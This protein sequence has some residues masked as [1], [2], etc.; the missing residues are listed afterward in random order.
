MLLD[1]DENIT[2]RSFE[3]RDIDSVLA[4]T[5]HNIGT[6]YFT[7]DQIRQI[8]EGSVQNDIN[9]SLVLE[10]EK[11]ILGVRLTFMRGQG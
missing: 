4:F 5:D 9:C 3:N 1:M 2:I 11:K 8:Q 7:R 6:G 10:S